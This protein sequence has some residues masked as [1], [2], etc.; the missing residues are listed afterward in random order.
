MNKWFLGLALAAIASSAIADVDVTIP[1]Q[2]VVCESKQSIAT[3]IKRKG[4]ANKVKL[5]AGCKALDVKRRAEV[6]KRYSKLGYLEVKLNT[7]NRVYVDKDAIR[8]G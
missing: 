1:K 2:R 6:I 8:R 5:P 3:F 7:G 4:V